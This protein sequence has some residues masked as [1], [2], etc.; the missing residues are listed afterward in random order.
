MFLSFVNSNRRHLDFGGRSN[1]NLDVGSQ[2]ERYRLPRA[3]SPESDFMATRQDA[4]NDNDSSEENGA[5]E[6]QNQ[7]NDNAQS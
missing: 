5:E 6:E 7:N 4:I 1:S 3:H 2:A